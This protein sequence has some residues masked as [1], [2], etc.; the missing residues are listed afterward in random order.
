M[1][2]IQLGPGNWEVSWVATLDTLG[3]DPLNPNNATPSESVV[4]R[5]SAKD[6]FYVEGERGARTAPE[7]TRLFSTPQ[8]T[9][10]LSS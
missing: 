5:S 7:G 1:G 8:L 9:H 2:E 6:A 3:T 4:T 10:P